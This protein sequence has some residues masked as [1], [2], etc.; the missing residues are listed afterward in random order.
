MTAT[1][2]DLKK[3]IDRSLDVALGFGLICLFYSILVR[4]SSMLIMESLLSLDDARRGDG[5]LHSR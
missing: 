3:L 2:T 5:R 4:E 1:K